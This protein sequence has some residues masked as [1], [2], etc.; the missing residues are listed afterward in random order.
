MPIEGTPE[1]IWLIEKGT[2]DTP[3]PPPTMTIAASTISTPTN[4]RTTPISP[5]DIRACKAEVCRPGRARTSETFEADVASLPLP[6]F[7]ARQAVSGAMGVAAPVTWML[8]PASAR[9]LTELIAAMREAM[10]GWG[11]QIPNERDAPWRQ[12]QEASR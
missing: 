8:L 2:A 10:A 4:S 11:G 6:L 9:T 1:V 12:T 5:A 7:D 3:L